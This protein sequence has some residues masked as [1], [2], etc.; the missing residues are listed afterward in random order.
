[1]F[2]DAYYGEKVHIIRKVLW[3]LEQEVSC[4]NYL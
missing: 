4:P 3:Y 1:M 2:S